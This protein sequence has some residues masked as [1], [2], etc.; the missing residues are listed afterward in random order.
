[1]VNR[2][3]PQAGLVRDPDRPPRTQNPRMP[4]LTNLR[5]IMLLLPLGSAAT[6]RAQ[7][8]G[9]P[10]PAD[11]AAL[12]EPRQ[13]RLE[14]QDNQESDPDASAS[15]R[16]D[17]D[18]ALQLALQ[19]ADDTQ[20]KER[21]SR[22]LKLQVDVATMDSQGR[23]TQRLSLDARWDGRLSPEW[24]AVLANRVDWNL[25]H[26]LQSGRAVNLLKEAYVSH[27]F[28]QRT[29]IDAGRINTRYGVALGYNPTD[30]LGAG[31]VR[32]VVSPDPD[33]V[34]Q[35]RLGNAMVR[36]QKVWSRASVTAIWSPKLADRPNQSGGS[37]DW[38]ASNPRQ[39]F[40]LA[41]SYR[42]AENLNPQWLLLQEQ[43]RSPQLG[44]NVSRVLTDSTVAYL[45]WAGGRQQG[46][47]QQWQT[48]GSPAGTVAWRNR[49]ATGLTWTGNNKLSVTLEGQY[50]GAAPDTAE[51]KA[52]RSGPAYQAY[53]SQNAYSGNLAT[54]RAALAYVRWQD[55]FVTHL[56]LTAMRSSDLVDHSALNWVEARY[57]AGS[58]DLALQW[59]RITGASNTRYGA[60][61]ARQTWQF[62]LSYYS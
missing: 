16:P 50:D 3:S 45:E 34:R 20:F 49:F 10:Q 59:Q 54:R 28:D 6:A 41:G 55:A 12:E 31:T 52:L 26:A 51:W 40:L 33:S 56:D 23:N 38:G 17:D 36:G 27:E 1:M 7:D 2:T 46:A 15:T 4:F 30:F 14:P 19:L 57:H 47:W 18:E 43:G 60:N 24:R 5:F 58:V 21:R 32:S 13:K 11:E 42:F 35:N 39:R 9:T 62:V 48:P 53:L 61:P 29:M 44:F 22:D 25:S 37:L 8:D